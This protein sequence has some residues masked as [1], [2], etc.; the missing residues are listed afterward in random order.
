MLRD[1]QDRAPAAPGK[2]K[3]EAGPEQS[4]EPASRPAADDDQVHVVLVGRTQERLHHPAVDRLHA[5]ATT[6]DA[7]LLE[8]ADSGVQAV[9]VLSKAALR[10]RGPATGHVTAADMER[11]HL[12]TGPSRQYGGR[13]DGGPGARTLRNGDQDSI[14]GLHG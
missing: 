7:G 10:R 3:T 1:K 13:S 5:F 9:V 2:P 6:A 14:E 11:E 4:G 12:R 8:P